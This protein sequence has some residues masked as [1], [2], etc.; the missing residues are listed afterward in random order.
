MSCAVGPLR[1]YDA[2]R[3][4]LFDRA[5]FAAAKEKSQ[6]GLAH[7]SFRSC[8]LAAKQ[9]PAFPKTPAKQAPAFPK[10][11]SQLSNQLHDDEDVRFPTDSHQALADHFQQRCAVH[12]LWLPI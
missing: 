10:T 9:A 5:A 11:H 2:C 1:K 3:S 6:I 4:A 8:R 7:K 12:V